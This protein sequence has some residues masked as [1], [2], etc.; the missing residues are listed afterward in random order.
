MAY[1]DE[2]ADSDPRIGPAP[3]PNSDPA[4]PKSNPSKR[5]RR[6]RRSARPTGTPRARCSRRTRPKK[7]NSANSDPQTPFTPRP[8]EPL[9][10]FANLTPEHIEF[11]HDYIRHHTYEQ[12]ISLL[13]S[14]LNIEISLNR[15]YRYRSRLDLAEQLQIADS[16][17]PAIENLLG[18]LAGK[19]VDL[20]PAGLAVIKQ[21]ALALA[22][23]P[24][25]APSVLMN[26]FRI[27][28]WEHRKT[29]NEHRMQSIDRRDKCR[30][31]MA[32]VAERRQ[33][34]AEKESHNGVPT[35]EELEELRDLFGD[36]P[37]VQPFNESTGGI[38]AG[39]EPLFPSPSY[40]DAP[41]PSDHSTT[42]DTQ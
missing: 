19:S 15:L 33:D 7:Q 6:M 23:R 18:L 37:P 2:P 3:N 25:T 38:I 9:P 32:K 12:S 4:D 36:F 34:L 31:R 21:R 1:L 14:T 27:F 26:L 28:T 20:D 10:E 22:A 5:R 13:R 35:D 30:E 11:L 16:N 8:F 17:T 42:E 39:S 41:T 29:V 40:S 24:D